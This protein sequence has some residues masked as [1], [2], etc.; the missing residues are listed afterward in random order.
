MTAASAGVGGYIA[1]MT[2]LGHAP[3]RIGDVVVVP[4]EAV[5]G[6][7]HG[8]TVRV[9]VSADEL[10]TWPATPPHWIH[11]PAE[12][13]FTRTNPNTDATLPGWVRHSRQVA[14][15]GDA[16]HPA[17]AWLAQLRSVLAEAIT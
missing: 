9:G 13:T 17:A 6:G 2:A 12:I 7:R 4:V 8:Q 5:G 16:A 3:E 1:S 10:V 14:H 11:L 15:W